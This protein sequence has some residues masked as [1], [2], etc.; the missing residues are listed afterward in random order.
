[1]VPVHDYEKRYMAAFTIT[2]I[3]VFRH[4]PIVFC[5]SEGGGGGGVTYKLDVPV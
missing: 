1:M 2:M 4:E 5:W 3:G